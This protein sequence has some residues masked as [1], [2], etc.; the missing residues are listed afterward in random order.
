VK[1][2]YAQSPSSQW[3]VAPAS[4]SAA[5]LTSAHREVF[6]TPYARVPGITS[7]RFESG[8]LSTQTL[9][10]P[11]TGGSGRDPLAL[12]TYVRARARVAV[13][14]SPGA[15]PR[16][17][18]V[19]RDD[20][21][22]FIDALSACVHELARTQGGTIP[23][24]VIREVVE[25]LIHA[26]FAEPVVSIMDGGA[27][28]RFADQGPGIT[29]KNRAVLPGFTTAQGEMKRFI[30]GVGSGL[31]IVR[32]YLGHSGG[33]LSL[34]DNLGGGAVI[35]VRSGLHAATG[36]VV[37]ATGPRQG[38]LLGTQGPG[39]EDADSGSRL[40]IRQ[41]QVLAL[42]LESGSAGPSLVAKELGIGVSTAYRDLASLEDMGLISADG[43]KRS[44]TEEGY[45]LLGCLSNP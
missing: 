10:G 9:T 21:A 30:R 39:P 16:V 43:G 41:K 42:V 26:D 37:S 4:P 5:L 36:S 23:Y 6:E 40:T 31:P 13:Y 35:T 15:A 27:T 32:E 29:D 20:V 14:D 2:F 1:T 3:R 17:V 18:D 28:I 45:S 34:E 24:P 7:P 22:S 33:S 11:S 44:L 8:A 38:S 12:T 19:E 25:N